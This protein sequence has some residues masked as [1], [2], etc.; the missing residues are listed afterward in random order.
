MCINII[1]AALLQEPPAGYS[2]VLQHNNAR[3]IIV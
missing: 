3:I 2:C 1:S